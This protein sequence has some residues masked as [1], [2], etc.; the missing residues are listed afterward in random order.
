MSI[1]SADVCS[2]LTIK[3]DELLADLVDLR[4]D[5]ITLR[6]QIAAIEARVE[7]LLAECDEKRAAC[8]A[9]G[10]RELELSGRIEA[11]SAALATT[12]LLRDDAAAP[13]AAAPTAEVG[14]RVQVFLQPGIVIGDMPTSAVVAR[15]VRG[16]TTGETFTTSAL[17]DALEVASKARHTLAGVRSALHR[18]EGKLVRRIAEGTQ[19]AHTLWA[20]M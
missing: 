4:A 12:I 16:F 11:V 10:P 14:P 9:F 13:A 17:L 2:F 6:E 15:V 3:R 5:R 19:G 7:Q 20:R 8:E 1:T 18:V